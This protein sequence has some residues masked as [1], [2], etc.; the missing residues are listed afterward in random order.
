MLPTQSPFTSIP[1]RGADLVANTITYHG[2]LG[3]EGQQRTTGVGVRQ[4]CDI[5]AEAV[6][7]RCYASPYCLIVLSLGVHKLRPVSGGDVTQNTI[8]KM[9][10]PV[11]FCGHGGG[12]L[13][14][15]GQQP[16]YL[17][18]FK[19]LPAELPFQ[20][21]AIVSPT[22][23]RS[24]YHLLAQCSRTHDRTHHACMH[25]TCNMLRQIACVPTIASKHTLVR[26]FLLWHATLA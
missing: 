11:L 21:S 5:V 18:H 7:Q 2:T 4:P 17:Q 9:S 14:L 8:S 16:D 6:R 23:S 26:E 1:L 15:T 13:P 22:L 10:Q 12:P 25:T 3:V 19:S 24:R 20:P